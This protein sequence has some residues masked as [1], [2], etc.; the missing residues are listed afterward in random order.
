MVES[1]ASTTNKKKENVSKLDKPHKTAY[2]GSTLGYT[3]G[4]THLLVTM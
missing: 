2:L 1:M 4:D 3:F